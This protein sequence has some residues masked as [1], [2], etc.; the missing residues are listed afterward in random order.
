MIRPEDFPYITSLHVN[1]CYT[2]QDFDI[3]LH[4]YQPFSHLILTGKNGSGKSTILRG[5]DDHFNGSKNTGFIPN[6]LPFCNQFDMVDHFDAHGNRDFT[7]EH[8]FLVQIEL[9]KLKLKVN[10]KYRID[11]LFNELN[12]SINKSFVYLHVP[13]TR[14][15]KLLPVSTAISDNELEEFL[16]RGKDSSVGW[17]KQYLVNKRVNQ[18]FDQISGNKVNVDQTEKF[19]SELTN[20][21]Q[22]IFEDSELSLL[23]QRE[24]FEFFI[25]LNDRRRITFN[26]LPEGLSAFINILMNVI[27]RVD[28]IRKEVN[29]FNY[30]PC[31]IVLID[32]PEVHLHL[33]LQEQILPLLTRLFPN[34]QFIVATHSPAVIASIKQTTIFD[35]TTKEVRGDEVVGRSYSELMTSHFKMNNE[36]SPIADDIFRQIN[37]VLRDYKNQPNELSIR[38]Q[39]IVADNETYISPSFLVEL[40][41]MILENA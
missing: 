11:T 4:D 39:K 29:D 25:K 37:D 12:N 30:D 26:D 41:S 20:A 38:V 7:K 3:P 18:A 40:E 32:E 13:A 34:I 15:I 22:R 21:F 19:F 2:Y 17:L 16:L 14:R 6:L 27:A 10:I 33:K 23:F 5:I 36:Y 1:D 9:N 31:G 8:E 28:I 35:L 24:N